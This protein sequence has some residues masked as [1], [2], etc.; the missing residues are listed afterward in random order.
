MVTTTNPLLQNSQFTPYSEIKAEHILPAVKKAIEISQAKLEEILKLLDS[1][2]V[3]TFQ[4]V[5]LA[6]I[7]MDEALDNA[8]TPV[9]NLLSLKG[10]K[11]IRDASE[12]ARPLMVEFYNNYSLDERVYKLVKAYAA[13]EEAKSLTG[14][15]ARHLEQSLRGFKLA[16]AELEGEDREEFKKLNLELSKLGQDFANNS[17]DSK[18]ELVITN[19]ADLA[20]LPEDEIQK[21]KLKAD[22][23]RK[24]RAEKNAKPIPENAWLFNLDAPSYL[25]FAKFADNGALRKEMYM[26][27]M[28]KATNKAS[29]PYEDKDLNNEPLIAKI[30]A[31]K[32]RKAQLLGF[33]NYAELSLQTKMAESPEQVIEFL[34]R[35]ATKAKP[36]AEK[37]YAELVAFQKEIGYQNTEN[38]PEKIFPWDNAYLSEKLRK[39]R[40]DLDTNEQKK[41]FELNNVITGMFEI[42][43]RVFDIKLVESIHADVL[44]AKWNDEVIPYEIHDNKTNEVI[45]YIFAD[46][47]PRDIKR[48]GAWVM[49]LVAGHVKDDGSYEKPQCAMVTNAPKPSKDIPSLLSHTDVVTLFHEFG[50]ALHHTL[51]KVK[52]APLS[53]TSVEW[54]FVELPSQLNENFTWEKEGLEL[55]AKHHETGEQIPQELLDKMLAARNFNEGLFCIR[56]LE[57]GMLDLGVYMRESDDGK[58]AN[59]L[60]Q[61][62]TKKYGVFDYVEGTNFPCAFGHI[63]AGGYSAGYYSYKWAEVL[64][65]DAFSRFQREGV[66]NPAVG[67]DYRKTILEKGDAEAPGKLFKDFMGREPNED[68]LLERMGL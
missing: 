14:E 5:M 25:P 38:N 30:F 45:A 15:E 13:T 2:E 17:M 16:G 53:G 50:H 46:Y 3:L 61:E 44:K 41:Y 19:E 54:D 12:E 42:A 9:E 21:A 34:E 24:E 40:Y 60:Y 11:D 37:E 29:N 7:N 39:A 22:E 10:E 32:T 58:T 56:Q 43:E 55:F 68:A 8:W 47:F 4:N 65:A 23:V 20:G 49:P 26:Q 64:D 18:F 35:L 66:L 57:F 33:K 31:A 51:S 36:L 27:Y 28:N 6:L 48:G 63:F 62:V 59:E 52:L 1:G 67:A